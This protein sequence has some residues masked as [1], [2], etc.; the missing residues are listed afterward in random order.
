MNN[1]RSDFPRVTQY[2]DAQ[3]MLLRG[4]LKTG[5]PFISEAAIGCSICDWGH[6][7]DI[8]F[9]EPGRKLPIY[10]DGDVHQKARQMRKDAIADEHLERLGY[11]RPMHVTNELIEKNISQVVKEIIE[12]VYL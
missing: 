10:V 6:V 2:T 5:K 4:L 8:L 9:G 3:L 11:L 12:R 1:A 7:P